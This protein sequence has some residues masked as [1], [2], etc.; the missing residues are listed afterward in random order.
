MGYPKLFIDRI[1]G[2][3]AKR[4]D[5]MREG[6]IYVSGKSA[7]IRPYEQYSGYRLAFYL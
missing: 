6:K 3:V 2:W 5:K 7:D 4:Q 1:M